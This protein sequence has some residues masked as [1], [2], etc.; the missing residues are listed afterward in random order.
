MSD[1]NKKTKQGVALLG[2][3]TMG[4]GMAGRL[5]GSGFPLTVYNR[6]AQKAQEL[7]T[8]D[9][10]VAETPREAVTGADV[11]VSMV[12]DDDAS[13]SMWLGP[14]GALAGASRGAVLVEASTLSTAWVAELA[15][16]A[17]RQGCELLDTPVTGSKPQAASGELLFLVGGS[18]KALET[19][20][21]VLSVMSRGIVHVGPSGSG[22]LLKLINNFLCGIQAAA[23]GEALALIAK[24]GLNQEKAFEVLTNGAPGSPL[25]KTLLSRMSTGVDPANFRLVLMTKDL[26]YGLK[27]A[28]RRGI[29]VP[30]VS[31][32]HSLFMQA[33]KSGLGEKDF[34]AVAG[35]LK[36][37]R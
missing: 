6:T 26:A 24:G 22:A 2:L 16:A 25:M 9:A 1:Q 4:L 34:A 7:A 28:E 31:T 3:G 33:V 18:A 20:R 35:P 5:M 27:E 12:A 10:R 32:A 14:R 21:P 36:T 23:L 15:Q 8:K 30:M 19:A 17:A 37:Q 13:R 11:I 29:P